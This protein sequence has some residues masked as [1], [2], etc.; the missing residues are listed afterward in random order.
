MSDQL[1][2]AETAGVGKEL[3]LEV[4]G[5]PALDDDVVAIALEGRD[6]WLVMGDVKFCCD[7]RICLPRPSPRASCRQEG[8][9]GVDACGGPEPE[10]VC[11]QP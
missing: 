10:L 1:A 7:A 5:D 3:F 11:S 2:I 4:F 9:R 8:F 6:I